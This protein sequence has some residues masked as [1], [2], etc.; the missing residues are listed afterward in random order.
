[1]TSELG[2]LEKGLCGLVNQNIVGQKL[3]LQNDAELDLWC[4]TVVDAYLLTPPPGNFQLKHVV[5][6]FL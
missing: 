2:R 1:M 6:P 4:H 3:T 5:L